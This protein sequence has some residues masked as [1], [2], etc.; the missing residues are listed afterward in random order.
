V[1]QL[2]VGAANP[3]RHCLDQDVAVIE[4]RFGYVVE[5]DRTVAWIP[6]S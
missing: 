4:R 5:A 1:G 2:A 6:E 3:E